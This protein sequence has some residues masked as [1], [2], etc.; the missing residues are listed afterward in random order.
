MTTVLVLLGLAIEALLVAAIFAAARNER[1]RLAGVLKATS[2]PGALKEALTALPEA[3]RQIAERIVEAAQGK[4]NLDEALVQAVVVSTG[5]AFAPRLM[6]RLAS[7]A[8]LVLLAFA[9]VIHGAWTAAQGIADTAELTRR[10]HKAAAYV[11]WQTRLEGPFSALRESF[12]GSGLLLVGLALLTALSWWLRRPEVREARFVRALLLLATRLKPG[13]TLPV[14]AR[15]AEVI[16]PDRGLA[17]PMTASL[18][19]V[20]ATTLG[21]VFL[22]QTAEVRASNG[23]QPTFDVWPSG[24]RRPITPAP[25]LSLPR[26]PGG[27][28]LDSRLRPTLEIGRESVR[29]QQVPLAELTQGALPDPWEVD[30]AAQVPLLK[31]Y[32]RP[33]EA[34]LLVDEGASWPTVKLVMARLVAGLEVQRFQLVVER[35]VRFGTREELMQAALPIELA[36]PTQAPSLRLTI[37]PQRV[38]VGNEAG[39]GLDRSDW[40][41]ALRDR[42]RR[43]P[44]LLEESRGPIEVE[45][46]PGTTWRTLVAVLTAADSACF[47]Q[48]DCGLPGQGFTF[49]VRP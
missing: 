29:L 4:A 16:A 10:A 25:D 15:L 46:A 17:R 13:Q 44:A 9:P 40:P 48:S 39:L 24:Q 35:R 3:E 5:E 38:V 28:P 1:L 45:V 22:Q 42:L 11:E 14:G 20:A 41:Q 19:W 6:M 32:P 18:V 7:A 23:H 12:R 2:D 34:N 47:G 21:W 43:E 36:H 8:G 49:V 31:T 30:L 37:A 27:A 33:L 26:L